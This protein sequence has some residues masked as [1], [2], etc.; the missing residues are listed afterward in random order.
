MTNVLFKH[1]NRVCMVHII[2]FTDYR[3]KRALNV[4]QIRGMFCNSRPSKTQRCVSSPWRPSR[5]H[6][7]VVCIEWHARFLSPTAIACNLPPCPIPKPVFCSSVTWNVIFSE[8]HHKPWEPLLNRHGRAAK[9]TVSGVC[10]SSLEARV[11]V[12]KSSLKYGRERKK[13]KLSARV[14]AF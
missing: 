8:M 4:I 3:L 13:R 7:Q 14:K 12:H 1:N 11:K 10:Q 5:G 2:I 6:C 9:W